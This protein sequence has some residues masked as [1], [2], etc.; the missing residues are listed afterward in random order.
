MA[1]SSGPSP[2]V[3]WQPGLLDEATR[4]RRNGHR[5]AVVWL[6]GLPGSGKSTLAFSAELQ[7]HAQGFQ[8]AVLDGDNLRHGLCADLGFSLEDRRE[9]MRRVGEV[10]RLFAAQGSVVLVA[11]VSPLRAARDLMRAR[12]PA[13]GFIEVHCDCP[14]TVCRQ[15]DPKGLY[16]KAA[17]GLI[18]DFTGVSSPYEVP[19]AP[20]LVLHTAQEGHEASAQ[21]LALFLLE[22]LRQ[23][24]Q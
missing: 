5:G 18:S 17:Q 21:R 19:L 11:L 14:L 7:L 2:N 9:N 10:A 8:T 20:E 6:T 23:G 24:A 16:A 22:R 4:Q 12:M 15:R 13:G 3:V 1:G